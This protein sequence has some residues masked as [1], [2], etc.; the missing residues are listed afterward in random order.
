MSW[1]KILALLPLI[2][3]LAE[4]VDAETIRQIIAAIRAGDGWQVVELILRAIIGLAKVRGADG[5]PA[6]V[7]ADLDRL[8]SEARDR[9]VT[10]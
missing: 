1:A 2:R 10:G 5:V 6:D 9:S 7:L 3:Q 8:E 4:M